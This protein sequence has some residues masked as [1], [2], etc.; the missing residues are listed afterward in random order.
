[1]TITNE[2]L[3]AQMDELDSQLKLLS[4]EGLKSGCYMAEFN[5]EWTE[6]KSK[7]CSKCNG[8]GVVE[9]YGEELYVND[10]D[11]EEL[12]DVP[13]ERLCP[14]CDG[15]GVVEYSVLHNENVWESDI[16]SNIC[17]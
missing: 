11:E 2:Q 8:S 17:I 15:E 4:I 16:D 7:T 5:E 10:M 13:Y 6:P 3:L 9:L 1:M 12:M 14:A